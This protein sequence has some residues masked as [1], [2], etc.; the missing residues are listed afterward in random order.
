MQARYKNIV[1][2]ANV[3]APIN[4]RAKNSTY[5]QKTTPAQIKQIFSCPFPSFHNLDPRIVS[6]KITL[7]VA[8]ER[9]ISRK[10]DISQY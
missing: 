8:N 6:S 4:D 10:H 1:T 9:A 5:P 2:K 7:C 3:T